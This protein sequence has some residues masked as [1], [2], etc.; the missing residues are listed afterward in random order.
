MSSPMEEQSSVRLAKTRTLERLKNKN[1]EYLEKFGFIF[2]VFATGKLPR[3]CSGCLNQ[4]SRIRAKWNSKM[5]QREQSD[6]HKDYANFWRSY[7]KRA[8]VTTHIL[9]LVTGRPSA[10][11][12]VALF[13]DKNK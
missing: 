1:E 13:L 4:D 7:M 5:A 6:F 2:I 8:P 10:G 12:N 9:D 3:R 11:V